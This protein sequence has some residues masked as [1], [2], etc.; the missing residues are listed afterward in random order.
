MGLFNID[1]SGRVLMNPDSIAIPTF[2]AL[3]DR[4]KSKTKERATREISYVVFSCDYK[5]PYRAYNEIDRTRIIKEDFIKDTNWEPD[6]LILE[7]IK[8]YNEFQETTFSRLVNKSLKLADKLS[9]YMDTID[10][11]D[12]DE[13]QAQAIVDSIVKTLEKVGNIVKSLTML[14]K[15]VETDSTEQTNVRGKT[16][17]GDYELPD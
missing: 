12:K 9:D 3:W 15:Q 11:K 14:K 17:I 13:K 5:S 4:D 6:E 10:F 2:R 8:R 1:A 16:E 7:A